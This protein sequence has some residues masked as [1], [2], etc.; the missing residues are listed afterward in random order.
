MARPDVPDAT[1]FLPSRAL[2]IRLAGA[3][4]RYSCGRRFGHFPAPD[5]FG[6]SV[7]ARCGTYL[8]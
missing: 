1:L 3:W 7:C 6:Y 4:R 2:R 5:Y 8:L